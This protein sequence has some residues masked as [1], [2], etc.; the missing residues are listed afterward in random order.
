M[1]KKAFFLT[2]LFGSFFLFNSF[3][4]D[5]KT[6][7]EKKILVIINN[8]TKKLWTKTEYQDSVIWSKVKSVTSLSDTAAVRRYGKRGI[9]GALIIQY[10]PIV[11]PNKPV[12]K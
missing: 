9:N 1:I 3:M 6:P 12:I 8:K 7:V 11:T 10:K 2:F 4:Q 5:N